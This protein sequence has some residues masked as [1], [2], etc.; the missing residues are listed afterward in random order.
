MPDNKPAGKSTATLLRFHLFK[1]EDLDF[2]F[3]RAL[4]YASYDG[5]SIGES[6]RAVSQVKEGKIATW[7]HAW[8]GEAARVEKLAEEAFNRGN[9]DSARKAFLRAYN[10][11]RTAEFYASV[12][13]PEAAGLYKKSLICFNQAGAL[14]D[15]PSESV[16]IPYEGT[17]LPGHFFRAGKRDTPG[18]TI[19]ICGGAD[20]SGEELYFLG[21]REALDHGYNVLVFHGPG[22]RGSLH[23]NDGLVF[24]QDYEVPLKAVVDYALSRTDV[25]KERL[26]L[27]GLSLGGYFVPRAPA[28]DK[29]IG[30]LIANSPIMDFHL[31]LLRHIGV[32][33]NSIPR[34]LEGL[35]EGIARIIMPGTQLDY[36]CWSY[37]VT[38]LI[39]Y[40]KIIGG[41]KLDE[42]PK[43]IKCPTLCLA[44]EGE[45][46]ES[47]RQAR[48]FYDMLQC[49]K[50]FHMFTVEEGAD[51]HCQ[52]NNISLSAQVIF[53]WLDDVF[54]LKQK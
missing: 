24:R 44:S 28:A 4:A 21:G 27:Y 48:E 46:K 22:Q 8:Q 6:L 52:I 7:V 9:R 18:P 42:L 37:G 36:V 13:T 43:Q 30:A 15:P 31:W 17:S 16:R 51:S 47:E 40:L 53:N 32:N 26:A 23:E 38:R 20:G 45:G 29:R 3:I 50:E 11:Y 2:Q 41:F 5:A 19:I 14:F 12:K 1:N 39:D 25:D 33:L 10:Y 49:P 54:G 34:P 35:V